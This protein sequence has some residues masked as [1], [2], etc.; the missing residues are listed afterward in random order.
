[1]PLLASTLPLLP[2]NS[3]VWYRM[4]AYP[5][6]FKSTLSVQISNPDNR[7]VNM[8]MMDLTGRNMNLKLST[9]DEEG[10]Y[11]LE[12]DHVQPGLYFLRVNIGKFTKTMKLLKE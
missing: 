11:V 6:P 2:M 12:T 4:Q 8:H 3:F 1:M 5:N 7:E 9:P 10:V